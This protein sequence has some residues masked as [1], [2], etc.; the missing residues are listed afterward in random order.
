LLELVGHDLS[1]CIKT[2]AQNSGRR[3]SE[4]KV[5]GFP[6]TTPQ[7]PRQSINT[8]LHGGCTHRPDI[9]CCCCSIPMLASA[10]IYVYLH[11]ACTYSTYVH[12]CIPYNCYHSCTQ[13]Q[14][15]GRTSTH[16]HHKRAHR[17]LALNSPLGFLPPPIPRPDWVYVE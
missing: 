4:G 1:A 11:S 7:Q 12:V 14:G 5:Q 2:T 3:F 8:Q 15:R 16:E 9:G 13:Y 10:R 17:K 6:E